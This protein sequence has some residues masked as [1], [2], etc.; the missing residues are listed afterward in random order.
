MIFCHFFHF[1]VNYEKIYIY[2]QIYNYLFE[3]HN[4]FLENFYLLL[5]HYSMI[6]LKK[7]KFYTLLFGC[8]YLHLLPNLHFPFTKLLQIL[9]L[10][11][12]YF[13]KIFNKII[14]VNYK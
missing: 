6:I 14:N 5:F 2:H 9:L 4:K 12:D 3:M 7:I 10:F 1:Y 13:C 8:K 11:I